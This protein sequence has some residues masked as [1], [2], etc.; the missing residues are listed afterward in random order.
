MSI[1]R[2]SWYRSGTACI[3]GSNPVATTTWKISIFR[4]G[5]L[6]V[7]RLLGREALSLVEQRAVVSHLRA[8]SP[9]GTPT[10][11]LPRDG[12]T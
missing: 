9:L 12:R 6:Q 5:M 2:W 11:R 8:L 4:G 10:I 7:S 3:P 1:G